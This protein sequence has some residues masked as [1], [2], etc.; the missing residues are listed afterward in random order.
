MQRIS[1][2]QSQLNSHQFWLKGC[3]TKEKC[4]PRG[5]FRLVEIKPYDVDQFVD[6]IVEKSENHDWCVGQSP[7]KTFKWPARHDLFPLYA[8]LHRC[9]STYWPSRPSIVLPQCGPQNMQ[10]FFPEKMACQ[11]AASMLLMTSLRITI[12]KFPY[13]S[14]GLYSWLN[15]V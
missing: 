10:A 13:L 2:V 6:N 14:S 11:L 15:A 4:A 7:E 12:L 3:K 8:V 5:R 1:F 9:A